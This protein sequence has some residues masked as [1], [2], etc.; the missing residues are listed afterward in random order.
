MQAPCLAQDQPVIDQ[1]S[2][3]NVAR[4]RGP[5]ALAERLHRN[6]DRR[7]V[8]HT[9]HCQGVRAPCWQQPSVPKALRAIAA[10]NDAADAKNTT[11]PSTSAAPRHCKLRAHIKRAVEGARLKTMATRRSR[12]KRVCK[13]CCLSCGS[14]C[15][16]RAETR[17]G[18]PAEQIIG[19]R[20]AQRICKLRRV[21]HVALLAH[22]PRLH[23]Q[24]KPGAQP[25]ARQRSRA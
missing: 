4:A 7:A 15:A 11:P 9:L 2:G 25:A 19:A 10:R 18:A 16:P 17:R 24:S 23:T 8:E 6:A 3:C 20:A 12:C 22:R 13:V 5:R 14:T 1:A 21:G